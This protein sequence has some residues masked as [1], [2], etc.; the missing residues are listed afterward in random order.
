MLRKYFW[1]LLILFA[2]IPAQAG[3][4][5]IT[6]TRHAESDEVSQPGVELYTTS[7]CGYCKKARAFFR[8]R[9]ISFTE[10]DIE[11]NQYAAYRKQQLDPSPGVPF[12]LING[13]GIHG[14]SEAMYLQALES[15][16]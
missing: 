5:S 10:Y 11:K 4:L 8:E 7:W 6:G 14:Y 1:L 9:G 3:T 2:S 16:Q 13:H 15:D 12:A